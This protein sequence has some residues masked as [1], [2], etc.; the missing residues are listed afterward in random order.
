MEGILADFRGPNKEGAIVELLA[1][2]G[3]ESARRKGRAVCELV[4]LSS[5]CQRKIPTLGE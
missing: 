1:T 3:A 5:T 2:D 4:S